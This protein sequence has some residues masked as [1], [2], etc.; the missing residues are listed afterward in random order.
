MFCTQC[1]LFIHIVRLS[2]KYRLF[3]YG[4]SSTQLVA[5]MEDVAVFC[6]FHTASV[7]IVQTHV[8]LQIINVSIKNGT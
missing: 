6:Q 5:A 8:K 4:N 2:E 3:C 1:T 7:N